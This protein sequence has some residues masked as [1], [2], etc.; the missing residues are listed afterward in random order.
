MSNGQGKIVRRFLLHND[1]GPAEGEAAAVVRGLINHEP[2]VEVM[3]KAI[4]LDCRHAQLIAS[5]KIFSDQQ[6]PLVQLAAAK[7]LKTNVLGTTKNI[8]NTYF[9]VGVKASLL[10]MQ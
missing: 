7:N 8:A 6:R 1:C 4:L 9:H 2:I 10:I 3:R 5:G